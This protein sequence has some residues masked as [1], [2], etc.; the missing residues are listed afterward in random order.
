MRIFQEEI[1]G[2]VLS[3]TSFQDYDDAIRIANDTSA[4]SFL[5]MSR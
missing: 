3:L 1:F 5:P 2:P 4:P